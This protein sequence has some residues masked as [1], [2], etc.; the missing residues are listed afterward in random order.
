VSAARLLLPAI[1]PAAVVAVG[2]FAAYLW[3]RY[4]LLILL[5]SEG[6]FCL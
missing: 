3:W 1:V 4:G 2:S 6:R 5:A